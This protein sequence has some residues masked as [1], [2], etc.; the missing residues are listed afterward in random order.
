MSL[1]SHIIVS[2]GALALILG[3]ATQVIEQSPRMRASLLQGTV[4]IGVEHSAPLS[5]RFE[6]TA[7]EGS[8]IV[9][10]AHDSNETISV[11]VPSDWKRGEVSGAPIADIR[12]D[13]PMFGFVRWHFPPRTSITFSLQQAPEHIVMHNPSLATLKLTTANVDL[14]DGTVQRDIFLIQD[15]TIRIW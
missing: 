3:I 1:R 15:S 10:I 5:M 13:P 11:S 9:R 14:L 8:A 6:Y 2:L 4:D 12:K 7:R